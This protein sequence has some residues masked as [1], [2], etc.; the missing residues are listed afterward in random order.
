[1]NISLDFS[2]LGAKSARIYPQ[3]SPYRVRYIAFAMRYTAP[4]SVSCA[5]T[6]RELPSSTGYALKHIITTKTT[7]YTQN[8]EITLTKDAA[9]RSTGRGR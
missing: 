5:D 4:R 7:Y 6:S 8:Y 2:G 1:M 3:Q 9:H